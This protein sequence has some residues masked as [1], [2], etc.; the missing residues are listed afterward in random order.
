MVTKI[1]FTNITEKLKSISENAKIAFITSGGT[2]VKLEKNSVRSLENFSTGKRGALLAES[3]LREEYYVIF[4]HRKG[5]C[6]PYFHHFT[7]EE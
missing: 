3:F 6:E 7:Q 2:S 4:F 1:N 5:S